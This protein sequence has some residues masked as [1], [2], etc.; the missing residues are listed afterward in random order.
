MNRIIRAGLSLPAAAVLLIAAGT[1]SAAASGKAHRAGS[2]AASGDFAV[3]V[4]SGTATGPAGIYVHVASNPGQRVNV[5]WD[6]VCS[7]G[8]GA[9]SSS[10]RF[11]ART[12]VRR[13]VHHPY[14]HPASCTV[15]ASAQLN[16]GGSLHVW[17]SY[18]R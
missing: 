4:A 15:A 6:M 9:G 13:L 18:R 12:T 1:A 10:G 17:I 8:D 5:S 14:A 11:S 16:A 3:C 7:K 2:C